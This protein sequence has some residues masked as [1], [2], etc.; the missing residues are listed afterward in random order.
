MKNSKQQQMNSFYVK[1][2][3]CQKSMKS[4]KVC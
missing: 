2:M 3:I 4:V 1:S